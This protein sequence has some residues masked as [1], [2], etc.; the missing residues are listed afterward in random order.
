MTV[1]LL[2][3]AVS[4]IEQS[5]LP[6]GAR[7]IAWEYDSKAMCGVVLAVNGGVQPYVTWKFYEGDFA[8]TTNGCY[9]DTLAKA[10]ASFEDRA[11]AL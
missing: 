5:Q 6:N 3:D 9:F 1:K 7:L 8:T 10:A 2:E 4:I 11:R